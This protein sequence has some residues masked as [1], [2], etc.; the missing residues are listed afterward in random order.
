MATDWYPTRL[1]DL[2]EWW[3]NLSTVATAQGVADGL[4]ATQVTQ[5]NAD[6]PTVATLLNYRTAVDG[7]AEAYTEYMRIML[8][9]PLNTPLPLPPTPPDPID[10][11]VTAQ[12]ALEA[13]ARLYAG[14]LKADP[15][16]TLQKGELYRIVPPASPGPGTPA[17]NSAT[18]QIGSTVALA[19][20][21]A[22]YSVLAADMRRNGGDW[23]QIGIAMTASFTDS[24]APLVPGAPEVREY[25]V[26]GMLNSARVGPASAIVSVV[27]TP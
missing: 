14:I 24:T 21:K 9:A 13:R 19:L 22:G 5:I 4:T 6:A 23:T 26:Q 12:P 15:L 3:A 7:F 27:T 18:P 25:R 20:F 16:Y 2:P 11:L 8:T 10:I 1:T 17:I